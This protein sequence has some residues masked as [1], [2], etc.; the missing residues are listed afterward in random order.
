[1]RFCVFS[2]FCSAIVMISSSG[3]CV[4]DAG[5]MLQE[6]IFAE[7]GTG[8]LSK[9]IEFYEEALQNEYEDDELSARILLHLGMCYERIEQLDR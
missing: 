6:G 9:A 7:H 3:I 4:E 2:V 8:D 5:Q 1:M